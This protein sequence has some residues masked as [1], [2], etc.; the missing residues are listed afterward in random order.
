MDLAVTAP[1]AG[2]GGQGRTVARPPPPLRR[3]YNPWSHQTLSLLFP[4]GTHA[5]DRRE[6]KL[7]GPTSSGSGP[8]LV[9]G[10]LF[11]ESHQVEW[12][13]QWAC[14][15]G[16]FSPVQLFATLWTVAR[17]APLAMARMKY[18]QSCWVQKAAS[19]H[20]RPWLGHF[21]SESLFLHLHNGEEGKKI[22]LRKFTS[23]GLAVFL[24]CFVFY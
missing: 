14:V 7:G 8:L 15:L 21:I 2:S 4:L 12:A 10:G 9:S 16:G 20:V 24:F 23:K 5:G 6:C 13:M 18:W 1:R 11:I 22:M 3:G 17:Q 19:V